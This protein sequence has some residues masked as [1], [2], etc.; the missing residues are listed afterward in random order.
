VVCAVFQ[1]ETKGLSL[2]ALD[3]GFE[4]TKLQSAVKRYM[5]FGSKSPAGQSTS[6]ELVPV[7][8]FQ[9]QAA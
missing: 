9:G 5:S 3:E 2:D 8:L 4:E 6:V 7:N 1:P